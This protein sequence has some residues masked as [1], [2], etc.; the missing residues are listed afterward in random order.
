[1]SPMRKQFEQQ[2]HE[3]DKEIAKREEN[4]HEKAR[5]LDL[6]EK[7][8]EEK[9]IL[10]VSERLESEK[11]HLIKIESERARTAFALE[12]DEKSKAIS[13]MEEILKNRDEKLAEAQKAQ[14]DFLKKQRELEDARREMD[15][16]I[17]KRVS[18]ELTNIHLKARQEA[19]DLLKMKISEKDQTIQSMQKKIEELK[20]KAD[21]TSQQLQGEVLEL[22]LEELLR[23]KFIYDTIE[24]VAKGVTGADVIQ[25]VHAQNGICCG[26]IIWES[27]RTKSWNS[28]WLA[29]LRSDQRDAK[30]DIAVIE[31]QVL[32]EGIEGFGLVEN[33]WV[34][35]PKYA[36]PMAIILRHV[37]LEVNAA[38]LVSEGVKT[39]TELLY[40][41]LTGNGFRQRIEAIVE[42][43]STMKDDLDK[44]KK[45]IL[46][47]WAK[48]EQQLENVM[49]ATAGMYGDLQGIAGS[50]IQEIEGMS[51]LALEE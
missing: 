29:K 27:K 20:Q 5:Q 47:Q 8:I 2:L 49:A 1:M 32:P 33:V 15:L 26:T 22:Q 34:C 40:Q 24:P 3:K 31:T 50:S 45:A 13:D 42:A 18:D 37:L 36:E 41:Y 28:G 17:Q 46:K 10:Q 9:I 6:Q 25:K 44:E 12:L 21:Q 16:E 38:K 7:S 19:E 51:L 11:K 30:A 4:I 14:A 48:R 43:F 35:S 39:K 23:N